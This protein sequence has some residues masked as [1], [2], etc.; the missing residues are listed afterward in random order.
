MHS[1]CKNGEKEYYLMITKQ[2]FY[3]T[4]NRMKIFLMLQM[5]QKLHLN[6]IHFY[7]F[8]VH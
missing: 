4:Q 2:R 6:R 7:L 5:V 8:E 3:T 1:H